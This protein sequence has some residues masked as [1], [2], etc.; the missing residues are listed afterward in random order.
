MG[1]FEL[2][3]FAFCSM[4]KAIIVEITFAFSMCHKKMNVIKIYATILSLLFSLK[5]NFQLSSSCLANRF[6]FKQ[7]GW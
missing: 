3:K 5:N 7:K 6:K 1:I 4:R 2:D